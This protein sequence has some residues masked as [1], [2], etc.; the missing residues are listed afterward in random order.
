[1]PCKYRSKSL[2]ACYERGRQ[3][4][5]NGEAAQCPYRVA[6]TR[7]GR[8]RVGPQ[9]YAWWDGWHDAQAQKRLEE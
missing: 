1:M 2:V 3:A 9:H 6:E 4:F 8:Q 5:L 7:N